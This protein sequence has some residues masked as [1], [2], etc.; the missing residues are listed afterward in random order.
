MRLLFRKFLAEPRSGAVGWIPEAG[1]FL[2]FE[3][4]EDLDIFSHEIEARV[5]FVFTTRLVFAR[6]ASI[7]DA[8]I[9]VLF[10]FAR[11]IGLVHDTQIVELETC[12][13]AGEAV[14]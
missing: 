11:L 7:D 3:R 6:A 13:V 8:A 12:N 2:E 1:K 10:D 14:P 9:G 5:A 4:L